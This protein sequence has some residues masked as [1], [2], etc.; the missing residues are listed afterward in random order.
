MGA[1]CIPL[2]SLSKVLKGEGIGST[3]LWGPEVITLFPR[4]LSLFGRILT[5]RIL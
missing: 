1:A 2:V 5:L 3:G 4:T